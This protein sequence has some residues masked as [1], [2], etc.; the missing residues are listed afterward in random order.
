M[1]ERVI[2][3]VLKGQTQRPVSCLDNE[4]A[5]LD[6][7]WSHYFLSVII[8]MRLQLLSVWMKV[9]CIPDSS[10]GSQ[11]QE[12]TFTYSASILMQQPAA[13]SQQG[14]LN[15]AAGHPPRPCRGVTTQTLKVGILIC[16]RH[17]DS[18]VTSVTSTSI[19]LLSLNSF[20]I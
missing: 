12:R 13:S 5:L 20:I 17:Q 11:H 19:K 8:L 6:S 18:Q 2:A 15:H 3:C 7:L 1:C 4:E 16:A 9:S 14:I 10:R